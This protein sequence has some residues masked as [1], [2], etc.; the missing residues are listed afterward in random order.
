MRTRTRHVVTLVAAVALGALGLAGCSQDDAAPTTTDPTTTDPN[1]TDP[2]TTAVSVS[3]QDAP[4]LLYV[5]RA[6]SGSTSAGGPGELELSLRDVDADTVWFQDRP[7]RDA[8]RLGT[9][10]FVD[11]WASNGFV[12]DAP[13]ATLEVVGDDGDR[14]THVVELRSPRWDGAARTLTYTAEPIEGGG[15][16]PPERFAAASLFIDDATGNSFEPIQL[17][18]SNAQ[19]GQ[20]VAVQLQS[21]GSVP[22]SFSAGPTFGSTW[23]IGLSSPTGAVP[24]VDLQVGASTIEVQTSVSSDAGALDWTMTLF[25]VAGPGVDEFYLSSASD[26]GVEVTAAIGNAEPQVVNATQTPFVWP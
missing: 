5:Q 3:D 16:A 7:G 9:G 23:G 13:N 1:T 15:G 24:V 18:V 25:L 6:G 21:A 2:T 14:S 22:V 19:P 12:E 26:P 17:S 8:G 4:G 20:R 11:E 10:E